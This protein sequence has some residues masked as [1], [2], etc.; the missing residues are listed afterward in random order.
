MPIGRAVRSAAWSGAAGRNPF[1]ARDMYSVT[2]FESAR[3]Q[4]FHSVYQANYARILGYAARR[5]TSPEDAADVVAETF[6]VAWRKFDEIPHGDEAALWLYGVARR[7]LYNHHRKRV[8]RGAVLEMLA[9]DYEEAVWVDP[10]PA[11][12]GVSPGLRVA[13]LALR[14]EDR[15]LL[16]LLVWETL[17][18]EQIAAVVGCSRTVAKVRVHRA[19]R[20]FARELEREG[21][22]L[23]SD[24]PLKP[25]A[26]TRHVQ[27]GRAQALPDTEA[28]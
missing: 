21:V 19:R 3:Q 8:S 14:A 26:L 20:R 1:A 6:T 9:R 28:M 22:P 5:T 16:G 12:A 27:A 15:D 23:A 17:T 4:R 13:W 2:M 11:M 24:A 25:L 18:M 10:L 7:V